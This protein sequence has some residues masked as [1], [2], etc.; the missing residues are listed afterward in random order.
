LNNLDSTMCRFKLDDGV[1]SSR[2]DKFL[3]NNV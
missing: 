3:T 2:H 1:A